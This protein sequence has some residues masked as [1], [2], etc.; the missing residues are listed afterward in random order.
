MRTLQLNADTVIARDGGLLLEAR[1]QVVIR[2]GRVTIRADHAVYDRKSRQVQLDGTVRITTPQ[3]E[4]T[5]QAATAQMTKDNF[6]ETVQASGR[7]GMRWP[8]RTLKADRVT[9]QV[10]DDALNAKGNIIVTFPPD[11]TVTGS[12][13]V[14]NG[15]EKTTVTGRARIQ[16]RDGF[17]EGDRLEVWGQGPTAVVS[18]HVVSVFQDTRIT[19][20][21][22]SLYAEEN[23]V[24][25]RNNVTV[26]RPGRALTAEIVSVYYRERRLVA[27]GRTIIKIQ[28]T[29]P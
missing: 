23:R 25:F 9:Y 18:G 24:V 27:E 3:N 16:N 11:L 4:L 1:G 7:V 17:I 2:D 10:K 14:A 20:A 28:E 15:T 26:S 8:D 13:L 19:A 21:S 12:A 5:A 6:L 29:P 22:A